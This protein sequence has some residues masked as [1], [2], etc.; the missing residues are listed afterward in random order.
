MEEG[1]GREGRR[2]EGRRSKGE[3]EQRGAGVSHESLQTHARTPTCTHTPCDTMWTTHTHHS[4][5]SH[6]HDSTDHS[7]R[8]LYEPCPPTGRSWK[9]SKA[10]PQRGRITAG[11]P[12][13]WITHTSAPTFINSTCC[14]LLPSTTISPHYTSGGVSRDGWE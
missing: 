6:W 1:I 2:R 7:P 14:F 8:N 4:P 5:L 9:L 13:T 10:P 3:Q 11:Q 12:C